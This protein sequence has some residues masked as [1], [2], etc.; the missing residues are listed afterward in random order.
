MTPEKIKFPLGAHVYKTGG[1]YYFE[2]IVVAAFHKLHGAAR[3][4]VENDAGILHIFSERQLEL[5][6]RKKKL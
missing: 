3:Y 1:D 5:V 4:V 6:G 2:G